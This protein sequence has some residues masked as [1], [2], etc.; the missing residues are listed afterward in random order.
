MSGEVKRPDRTHPCSLLIFGFEQR[1][2]SSG[3]FQ[4]PFTQLVNYLDLDVS[5]LVGT[6]GYETDLLA[7]PEG[8]PFYRLF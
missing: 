5:T 1:T 6:A 2:K 3:V 7:Q 8:S 4:L